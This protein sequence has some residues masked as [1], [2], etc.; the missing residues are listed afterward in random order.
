MMAV[1]L[2][3]VTSTLY[4]ASGFLLGRRLLSEKDEVGNKRVALT[5]CV[6]AIVFHCALLY[7]DLAPQAH[8]RLGLTNALSIVSFSISIVFAALAL[9]RPVEILGVIILP[10]AALAV[11]AAWI[12]P[13]TEHGMVVPSP[14]LTLH[15]IISLIAYAFL[16]LAVVQA[17]VLNTQ[18]KR[19]HERHPGRLLKNLPPIQTM[20]TM[21]FVFTGIGFTLLTLTLVSGA[22]YSKA[23]FGVTLAF[24][25]HTVL[26]IIAW[27]IFGTLLIGRFRFG[28]RGRYAAHWTISGFFVLVLAYF[29]TKYVAE[30]L[31]A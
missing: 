25:H 31:L 11:L 4:L 15:L 22:V 24:N 20:E 26:S 10:L 3:L 27:L 9:R 6:A 16:S 1:L 14:Q 30:Y 17:F 18:E 28:W 23:L 8:W 12:W 19:L 21:L 13:A 7:S 2:N 5:I 29:G